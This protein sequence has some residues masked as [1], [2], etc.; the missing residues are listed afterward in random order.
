MWQHRQSLRVCIWFQ[1][2]SNLL[3]FK[4]CPIRPHPHRP[5]CGYFSISVPFF[6]RV[7]SRFFCQH[8]SPSNLAES[9]YPF[10]NHCSKGAAKNIVVIIIQSKLIRLYKRSL[11]LYIEIWRLGDKV[12]FCDARLWRAAEKTVQGSRSMKPRFRN[13]NFRITHVLDMCVKLLVVSKISSAQGQSVYLSV[14]ITMGWRRT[15]DIIWT[16][17]RLAVAQY[18]A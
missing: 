4:P 14:T 17:G 10:H 16:P 2:G 9:R 15:M 8:D 6:P 11:S 18:V 5:L 1:E 13:T 3:F 12:E 7:A